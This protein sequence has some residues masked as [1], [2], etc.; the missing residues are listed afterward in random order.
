MEYDAAAAGTT[1]NDTQA[2][3][4]AIKGAADNI[5]FEGGR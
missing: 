2:N 5:M 3:A 4:A 1:E